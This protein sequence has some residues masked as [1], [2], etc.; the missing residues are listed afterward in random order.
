MRG[1]PEG[2][3]GHGVAAHKL[4][5]RW[6]RCGLVTA[7]SPRVG[8][9]GGALVGGPVATSLRQGLVLERHG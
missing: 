5:A 8:R 4:C 2:R 9:R 6:A 3:L 1:R 7:R